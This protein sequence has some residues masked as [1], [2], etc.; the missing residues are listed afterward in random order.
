MAKKKSQKSSLLVSLGGAAIIL[1]AYA[2]YLR[3]NP[4]RDAQRITRLEEELRISQEGQ[5]AVES[6]WS[7]LRIFASKAWN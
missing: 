6:S 2:A 7:W 4:S 5:I 1:S 3:L